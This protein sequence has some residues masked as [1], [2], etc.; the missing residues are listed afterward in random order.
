VDEVTAVPVRHI[1]LGNDFNAWR[2]WCR[3]ENRKQNLEHTGD[4]HKS[5]SRRDVVR[6]CFPATQL[7]RLGPSVALEGISYDLI[8][9]KNMLIILY[10]FAESG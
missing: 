6:A 4:V 10:N 5:G 3:H 2:S 9:E 1:Q 8:L 7:H